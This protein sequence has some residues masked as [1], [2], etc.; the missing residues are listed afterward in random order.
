VVW[1]NDQS[2]PGPLVA[3][4]G[5]FSSLI[6][7]CC[8]LSLVWVALCLLWQTLTTCHCRL[9]G[10]ISQTCWR[11]NRPALGYDSRDPGSISSFTVAIRYQLF[12]PPRMQYVQV[13]L[14]HRWVVFTS[15]PSAILVEYPLLRLCRLHHL[16]T[17]RIIYYC[18]RRTKEE[19]QKVQKN[20]FQQKILVANKSM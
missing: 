12:G 9:R 13:T 5:Y 6:Y 1:F 20:T 7:L 19:K 10:W 16:I 2:L 18:I 4:I 15:L 11:T 8:P 3:T 14:G 17:D